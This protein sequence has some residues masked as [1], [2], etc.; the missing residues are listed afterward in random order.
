MN[1]YFIFF[2]NKFLFLDSIKKRFDTEKSLSKNLEEKDKIE[3]EYL[4]K[5]EQ[6][7]SFD[8]RYAS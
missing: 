2:V 8:F 4:K 3:R 7:K 6:V 1:R 5:R